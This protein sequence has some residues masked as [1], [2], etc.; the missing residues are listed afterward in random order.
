MPNAR[1][2]ARDFELYLEAVAP[3]WSSYGGRL[4]DDI[5]LSVD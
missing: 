4:I 1:Q 5:H 2:T 3:S